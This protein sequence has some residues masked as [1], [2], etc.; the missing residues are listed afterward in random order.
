MW[1]EGE[2]GCGGGGG[3]WSYYGAYGY[4]RNQVINSGFA[5]AFG[6]FAVLIFGNFIILPF[7]FFFECCLVRP[8]M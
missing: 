3:V 6:P 2:G 1:D 4:G 8:G 5:F 7:A